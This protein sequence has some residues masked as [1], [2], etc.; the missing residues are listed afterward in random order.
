MK[1]IVTTLAIAYSL[2]INAQYTKLVDFAG[3]T[4]GD[5]P[6]GDLM[7]A[8]DGM[9]Y[10]MTMAGGASNV[11]VLFQY[12][13]V[14][15]TYIDKYDF[16]VGTNG[17][18]P[19]GS[20]MQA[21]DGMLYGMTR[22]GG[23]NTN[24]GMGGCGVLFQYNP[25][26]STYTKKLDFA[27]INGQS[28]FG[29]LMQANDGMLYGMTEGG[30]ANNMGVLFQYNP[31]TNVYTDKFDFAEGNWPQG[32]LMQASDG[33]L[34]GMTTVGGASTNCPNG[35]GVLF[36]WNPTTNTYT[37]KLD[38]AGATNGRNPYGDLMQAS[39]G[40]LYGMTYAGGANGFGVLFQYNPATNILTKKLDFAGATNGQRPYGSLMQASDGMLYGMTY[41]GGAN[42]YGV[43][44]QYTPA[45]NTYTKKLDFSG[46]SNGSNPMG[47]L[48]L[49][50]DGMLYGMTEAG[51]TFEGVLFKFCA[52]ATVTVT[53][54]PSTICIGATATLTASGASTYTWSTS[55][56][57]ATI[58]PSPTV[59]AQ[60]M[61]TGT[62]VNNCIN[63]ATSTVTVNAFPTVSV[64]SPTICIDSPTTLTA[65]GATTYSW[66][67]TATTAS[68][69]VT[70]TVTTTYIVT[71]TM[72]GCSA[73][74]SA[75]S[76]VTVNALPTITVNSGAI[77]TG[78]SFTMSPSGASTYTY[79]SGSAVVS[80]TASATY[81]VSGTD[82]NTC[83]NTA[84]ST[85]S[86]NALPTVSATSNTTSLCVDSTAILQAS[87][88][89]TYT[90]STS[91]TTATIAVTPSVTTTYSLSGTDANGCVNSG[92]ITQTVTICS[93]MGIKQLASINEVSIYPNPANTIINVE[94]GIINSTTTLQITD[95][96]GNTHS[97]FK[98]Q[99]SPFQIS[100]AD[101]SEGIYNISIS[102]NEGVVNK[103]VVIV[104]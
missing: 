7:Q 91:A 35:C 26:T 78:N 39:D 6:Q 69:S 74:A 19:Q 50:S 103:R 62:D 49:A 46:T 16:A 15:N 56:T 101:L 88:A 41:Q 44:F 4:N 27:G 86:V 83:T 31:S 30:G 43:I 13:P 37:K 1:K 102:S 72:S 97:T 32:S 85:V 60:Y 68:I 20:L 104:R 93:T 100:V 70:P 94:L 89:S 95:M 25:V 71:G 76:T 5:Y 29:T 47:S 54:S 10:G 61:V 38:F 98:I 64:N 67:T 23:A 82:V 77:C 18:K 63:T 79:S 33:M 8:T 65:S 55:A 73:S 14:T 84:T 96:L 3:T 11:G 34:Y 57:S 99:H 42:S 92:I 87:G 17:N 36:Q 12:N 45:T 53:E 81:T 66:N 58:T 2:N 59:T 51:G 48:M 52:P 9:L 24:C 22:F 80:P 28:P 21:T 75:T 90:W 40:M